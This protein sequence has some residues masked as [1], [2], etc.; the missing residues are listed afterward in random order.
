MITHNLKQFPDGYKYH[1]GELEA[2]S[3]YELKY[4]ES[5]GID[6]VWYWYASGSYEGCGQILMRK[7]DLYDTH[8][9]GHCSCYGPTDRISFNG[10]PLDDLIKA[11]SDD[12]KK[13]VEFLLSS[14]V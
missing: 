14:A 13:E 10:R 11:L 8:D 4:I 7:G 3:D 1:Y 12:L 2:L 5:L 6:E 9:A